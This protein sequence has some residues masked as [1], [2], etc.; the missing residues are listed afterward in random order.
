MSSS[1]TARILCLPLL[2]VVGLA[3]LAH[4]QTAQDDA[5]ANRPRPDFAPSCIRLTATDAAG[6]GGLRLC[7]TL[8]VSIAYDD[9]V[10]RT[11]DNRQSDLLTRFKPAVNISSDWDRHA[12]SAGL[13]AEITRFA[14][15]TNNDA[16]DYALRSAGRLDVMDGIA[17]N[18]AVSL[19]RFHVNRDDPDS[20]GAANDVDRFF[21]TTGSAGVTYGPGDLSLG[22]STTVRSYDYRDNGAIDNDDQDRRE[23]DISLNAGFAFGSGLSVFVTPSYRLRRYDRTPDSAGDI[24]DSAGYDIRA[25]LSYDISGVTFVEFSAGVFEQRFDDPNFAD[26]SGLSFAGRLLWNFTDLQ[27]LDLGLDR[28]IDETTQ[29]GV[30]SV[31]NTS[32]TLGI[33]FDIADNFVLNTRTAYRNADFESSGRNDDTVSGG[34]SMTYFVNEYLNATLSYDHT[35]RTS[36]AVGQDFRSNQLR[37]ALRVQM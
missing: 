21:L 5:V 31:I 23:Y 28:S 6:E 8:D 35:R 16:T 33:D 13:R 17:A 2:V 30:S 37:L 9:N 24:R 19:G 4:A 20:A 26:S 18:A 36:T 22:L 10:F 27:T 14:D 11:Q 3:S 34:L 29:A 1:L 15:V 12:V 7:P 32:V 25:G